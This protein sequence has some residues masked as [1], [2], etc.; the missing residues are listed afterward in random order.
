MIK[1]RGPISG[2]AAWKDDYVLTA[3]YDNQVILWDYRTKTALARSWHDHLA[4]QAVFSPD[5]KHVLTSSSDYTA[6]LWSVP[7]LRLEAVFNAQTDDVEMSVFHPEKELVATA[8]RDHNVRVYD[9]RGNLV[10]TFAGHTQ[11]V[12]SVEWAKGTDELISSSDDGTIKRWS[13]ETGGLVGDLDM[14]GVETDTIAISTSGT[15]YAGN[16]DGELIIINGDGRDVVPAH[17]AGVKRLVLDAARGLLVSLSYDRTMRLW[18]T[19]ESGLRPRG[20]A[21][22]PSDVWPRSCAFAGDSSLVFATFG[23]TYRSY[24][25]QRER[26][27]TDEIA[28]TGGINAVVPHE[29]S[30]LAVGDAGVVWRGEDVQARTGSLCNFLTPVEGLVFSGGQL[31]RVFDALTGAEIH[32]HRSPLNCGVAF[33]RDG[34]QHVVVG[35]YTGEGL[36]FRI[37]EPGKAEFAGELPLH[38]NAVKGVAVSGDL[39]FSV[40]ADTSATWYRISTL[41]KVETIEQ[42]HDRIAN[43]CVGLAGGEFASVSRDLRL[44]IWSASRLPQV[45]E[46]PHTHSVKCVSASDDGDLVATGAYNGRIAIYDRLASEWVSVQR[47]TTAGIS[48]LAYH[49]DEKLFLASSYDGQVH[50]ITV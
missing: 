10:A 45:V 47:P 35:A 34:V 17:D 50:R 19:V 24:D 4:N 20:R 30:T 44:R 36:L 33:R 26:W 15:I 8:S 11:D 23:A 43:G 25:F 27:E 9:F 40:C 3:G 48:S 6:R 31:G 39:L 2:I 42:A 13:L 7:E 16:D 49:P 37:P 38:A 5:G 32:R 18:E 21:D 14:D 46:T 41:E 28:G 29:D 12:I 22:L 1:H